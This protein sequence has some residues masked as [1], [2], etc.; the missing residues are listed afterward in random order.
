M[1]EI[2]LTTFHG[3]LGFSDLW[4]RNTV[5]GMHMTI[6]RITCLC[7]FLPSPALLT[8]SLNDSITQ[9]YVAIKPLAFPIFL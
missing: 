3:C 8:I 4:L 7:L 2:V 5:V 1:A 6:Q 9:I